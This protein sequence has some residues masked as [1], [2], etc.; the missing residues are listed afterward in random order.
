MI[1]P[2][3]TNHKNFAFLYFSVLLIDII[4]KVGLPEFPYRFMSKPWLMILLMVYFFYNKVGH[5]KKR[6]GWVYLALLSFLIGDITIIIHENVNFF[7][8]SILFFSIGKLFFCAKFSHKKDFEISKLIP[9]T[10]AIFV[11]IILIVAFLF[12]DVH[13]FMIPALIAF[14]LTL[15]ML[16]F[17][18]LRKGVYNTTSF[19]SVFIGVLLFTISESIMAI[20]TFKFPLPFEDVIIMLLYGMSV[21]F[22]VFG[23]INEKEGEQKEAELFSDD[24]DI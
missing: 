23:I 17:A 19:N 7:L 9:F 12:V 6:H 18:F 1:K 13:A 11:Y 8:I 15:L 14:F 20:K 21:Y 2:L 3:F 24:T 10:L 5:N 4:V 22:L 16:Q